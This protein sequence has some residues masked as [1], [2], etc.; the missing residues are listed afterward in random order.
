MASAVSLYCS[1]THRTCISADLLH[2]RRNCAHMH[3]SWWHCITPV[4]SHYIEPCVQRKMTLN[5]LLL[6]R[7][8]AAA[9]VETARATAAGG[10]YILV[11]AAWPVYER[12]AGWL[13]GHQLATST[14]V[15]R[16]LN[17]PVALLRWRG[18]GRGC[19]WEPAFRESRTFFHTVSA[20]H[21][22]IHIRPL[23]SDIIPH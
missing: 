18:Y 4:T 22:P 1:C 11:A 6:A 10:H 19:S 12:N 20:R 13:H 3:Q 2:C 15:E 23:I 5:W 16:C 9:P 7:R 8:S 21:H 14:L 17:E